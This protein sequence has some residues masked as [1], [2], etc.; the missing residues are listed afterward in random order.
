MSGVACAIL[1]AGASHRLG[2]PKQLLPIDGMPLVRRLVERLA[3][4]V[5]DAIGVV[6]G[7]HAG[8]VIAALDGSDVS[9]VVN[10]AWSE[11]MASSIR[12]AVAWASDHDALVLAVVDQP[13]LDAAH[14]ERLVARWRTGAP[15]V[16]SAYAGT[17]GAP[18]LFDAS[19]FPALA[20][21]HGDRGAAALVRSREDAA[22][23]DWPEGGVD[24]DT[25]ADVQSFVS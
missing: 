19:C 17:L 14:V 25:V 22:R 20:A 8:E 3:S 23:I 7:A 11:G 16:A 13:H 6:V 24:L 5:L 12:A 4:P 18:A 9:R 1:A 15:I 10:G 2:R 21:L